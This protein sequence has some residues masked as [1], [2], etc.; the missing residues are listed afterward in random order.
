ME[1]E[2]K[3]KNTTKPHFVFTKKFFIISIGNDY[4]RWD[5]CLQITNLHF[6]IL[7]LT[8]L[9]QCLLENSLIMLIKVYV[10]IRVLFSLNAFCYI[11]FHT[12]HRAKYFP[13]YFCK[14]LNSATSPVSTNTF[15][16]IL[17]H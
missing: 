16:S 10:V 5:V 8:I 6:I 3:N 2:T 11:I 14:I 17:T 13:F 15:T 1:E 12:I 7:H 4:E 9:Q